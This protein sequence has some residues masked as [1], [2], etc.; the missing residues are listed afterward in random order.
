MMIYLG[1]TLIVLAYSSINSTYTPREF[2]RLFD[3]VKIVAPTK[4]GCKDSRSGWRPQEQTPV[5][6][7][8]RTRPT[9]RRA[10]YNVRHRSRQVRLYAGH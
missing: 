6:I 2:A 3:Q 7:V 5:R 1:S 10:S 9:R 4:K 8:P